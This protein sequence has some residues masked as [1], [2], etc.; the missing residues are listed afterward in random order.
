MRQMQV[1]NNKTKYIQLGKQTKKTKYVTLEYWFRD[2]LNFYFLKKD[3]GIVS[4]SHFVHD[5]PK[6]MFC[7]LYSINCPGFTAWLVLLRKILVNICIAIVCWPGCDVIDFE[8]NLIFLIK[9][10][11]YMTKKSRQNWI[12]WE[13]KEFFR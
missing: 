12:S 11:F 5:F 2:M 1:A 3:L 8:I 10:F 7:K 9:S 4:T 6:K 13:Q